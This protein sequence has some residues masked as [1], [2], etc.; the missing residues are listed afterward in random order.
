[1]FKKLL[2]LILAV[3]MIMGMGIIVFANEN[4]NTSALLIGE[5]SVIVEA[6][7]LLDNLSTT[8]TMI[9]S[10]RDMIIKMLENN[11][12]TREDLNQELGAL[13]HQSILTLQEKGYNN[14]QIEIIKGYD[15]NQDAFNYIFSPD[16]NAR[17]A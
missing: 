8:Q 6:V 2:S 10:E 16:I 12:I 7:E 11:T 5:A 9:A 4:G 15:E 17:I 3:T 13:S 14:S 1:M